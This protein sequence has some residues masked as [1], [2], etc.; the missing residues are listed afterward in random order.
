MLPLSPSQWRAESHARIEY[1]RNDTLSLFAALNTATG[2]V[3][4]ET[5][6]RHTSEQFVAFR[7]LALSAMSKSVRHCS[8]SS[9]HAAIRPPIPIRNNGGGSRFG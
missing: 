2:E 9:S 6:A 4:G 3:P 8:K 1:K 7:S 5:A